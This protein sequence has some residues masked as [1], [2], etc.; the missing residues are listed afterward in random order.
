MIVSLR[1]LCG[2][3]SAMSKSRI[4]DVPVSGPIKGHRIGSRINEKDENK[5]YPYITPEQPVS[6]ASGIQD[7]TCAHA[8]QSTLVVLA[9]WSI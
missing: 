9:P 3:Y 7:Y 5:S 6:S 2:L 4:R 8:N 1:A